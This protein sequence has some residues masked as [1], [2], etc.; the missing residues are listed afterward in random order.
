MWHA[1]NKN[2]IPSQFKDIAVS[3]PTLDNLLLFR[4]SGSYVTLVEK[5]GDAVWGD[6]TFS[7]YMM[8]LSPDA[9]ENPGGTLGTLL[10]RLRGGTI[11]IW[12]DDQSMVRHMVF[13]N[14]NYRSTTT[15]SNLN[16][17]PAI[18]PPTLREE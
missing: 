1:F 13:Q 18:L 15:L 10:Q 12:I 9:P 4:D 17:P 5:K 3:G 16:A 2:S 6:E 14:D 11:D 8:K 7:R